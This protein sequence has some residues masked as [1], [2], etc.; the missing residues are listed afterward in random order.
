MSILY[1]FPCLSLFSIE[2]DPNGTTCCSAGCCPYNFV[3][4]GCIRA[5]LVVLIFFRFWKRVP[6][7]KSVGTNSNFFKKY[8]SPSDVAKY[9]EMLTKL[10]S[11]ASAIAAEKESRPPRPLARTR[12][13]GGTYWRKDITMLTLMGS[14]KKR[15]SAS[16]AS[17]EKKSQTP[18]FHPK[19]SVVVVAAQ[20]ANEWLATMGTLYAA[21]LLLERYASGDPTVVSTLD[22]V[23]FNVVPV[24][25]PDGFLHSF[26]SEQKRAWRRNRKP[27]SGESTKGV[28]IVYNW[29]SKALGWSFGSR[30]LTSDMYQG[31]RPFS[32]LETQAIRNF[33]AKHK[34]TVAGFLDVH[35][36]R[37]SVKAPFNFSKS[38]STSRACIT[39]WEK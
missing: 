39:R 6:L 35:C 23:S 7:S 12:A 11:S 14:A 16:K 9:T 1:I 18:P 20:H 27:H 13:I 22:A 21:S 34:S 24:T 25:N 26:E 31:P 5:R 10:W 19:P 17:K 38:Q 3:N 37:S 8:R 2:R 32:E 33:L 29:G 4:I 28:D 36:C 15:L 30:R